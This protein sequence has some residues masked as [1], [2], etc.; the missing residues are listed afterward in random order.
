MTTATADEGASVNEEPP[1]KKIR[2]DEQPSLN[3]E[4]PAEDKPSNSSSPIQL[5]AGSKGAR[6]KH[7]FAMLLSY[8]G[9]GYFG[10]QRNPGV[11]TIEEDLIQ[12]TYKAGAISEDMRDNLGKMFFQRCARTDK[13]VSA[14]RQVV[15]LKMS[16]LH[17]KLADL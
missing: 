13:G 15:S 9:K 1:L 4:D 16:V 17:F 8:C 11:R 3:S 12:A 10:M 2:L 7:K 14:V 6:G 5:L